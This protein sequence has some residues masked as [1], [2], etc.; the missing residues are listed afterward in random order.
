[1]NFF[2]KTSV[3]NFARV[4]CI[5]GFFAF[6]WDCA[7]WAS[8]EARLAIVS[9]CVEFTVV[10]VGFPYG[11]SKTIPMIRC[12]AKF[13]ADGSN[14]SAILT[15]PT[16]QD[17]DPNRLERKV[18]LVTSRLSPQHARFASHARDWSNGVSAS[19][20]LFLIGLFCINLGRKST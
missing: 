8:E 19:L 5:L 14:S 6:S 16:P 18:L 20:A 2:N 17:F 4:L 7:K 9:D 15:S 12:A 10:N 13:S 3:Y 1:M 11:S